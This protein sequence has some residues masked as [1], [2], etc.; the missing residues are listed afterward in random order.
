MAALT[1]NRSDEFSPGIVKAVPVDDNVHIYKGSLVMILSSTG[2]AKPASDTAST[3]FAGVALDEV[4][5][6]LTGHV[7]GGKTVRVRTQGEFLVNSVGAAQTDLGKDVLVVDD[8]TAKTA[9]TTNNIKC[10]S[11][12]EYISATSIRIN[13]TGYAKA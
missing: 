13:I 3:I 2:Y 11:V 12:A 9:A 1:T 6:T 4:D 7:A 8:N 10:G 5:N